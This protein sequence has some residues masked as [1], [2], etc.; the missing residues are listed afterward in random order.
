MKY[1]AVT[2]N[3]STQCNA[4]LPFIKAA[5]VFL[6]KYEGEVMFYGETAMLSSIQEEMHICYCCFL[7]SILSFCMFS[8]LLVESN[9]AV[10]KCL[11]GMVNSILVLQTDTHLRWISHT[12]FGTKYT[13]KSSF[14]STHFSKPMLTSTTCASSFTHSNQQNSFDFNG[15]MLTYVILEPGPPVF[16]TLC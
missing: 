6:H 7:P 5:I 8:N 10:L 14:P 1:V 11:P 4:I 16:G 15:A 13:R 3:T 12:S 2:S 9:M